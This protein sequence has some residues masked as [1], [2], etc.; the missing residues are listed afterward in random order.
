MQVLRQ[1]SR[2]TGDG[3]RNPLRVAAVYPGI[4]RHALAVQGTAFHEEVELPV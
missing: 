2:R 4:V 3:G 1:G